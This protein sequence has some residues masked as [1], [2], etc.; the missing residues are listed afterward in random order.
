[1]I[2]ST[3]DALLVTCNCMPLSMI[4]KHF[5]WMAQRLAS[6]RKLTRKYSA[7]CCRV[8]TVHTWKCMS[9]F[10]TLWAILWTKHEKGSLC[11]RSSILFWN[12][13]NLQRAT[14]PNQ[15]LWGF[16]NCP[17]FRN[18][19][20]GALPPMIGQSF[21]WA[22]SSSADIDGPSLAAMSANCLIGDDSGDL[23]TC[24]SFFTS[25]PF[26]PPHLGLGASSVAGDPDSVGAGW[27]STCVLTCQAF[28]HPPFG[29]TFIHAMLE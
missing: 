10:P 1:M 5:M 16:F 28:P 17:A 4:L 29:V 14:I 12:Q 21:F 15:Y 3:E 13:W 22:G 26:A 7:A 19:F 6:S 9:Y 25:S 20:Q 24:S 18:S 8:R 11:R 23:H 2:I 27:T